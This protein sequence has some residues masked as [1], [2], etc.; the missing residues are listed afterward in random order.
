MTPVQAEVDQVLVQLGLIGKEIINPVN[1]KPITTYENAPFSVAVGDE[2]AIVW[3]P[4]P[5]AEDWNTGG[6]SET[7]ITGLEQRDYVG[8]MLVKGIGQGL[9]G[10][11]FGMVTPYFKLLRDAYEAHQT[12]KGLAGVLKVLYMGDD[13]VHANIQY[14]GIDYYGTRAR[15]RIQTAVNVQFATG[16]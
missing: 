8:L 2:P 11:A 10:E 6:E 15:V 12:L 9:S 16:E 5:M 13:G 1:G 14:A 4:A 3:L 7:W